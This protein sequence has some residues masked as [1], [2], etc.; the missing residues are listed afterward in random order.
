MQKYASLCII[1][2]MKIGNVDLKDG[3]ILAPMAGV[4]DYT[5]RNICIRHGA[6]LTVTEMLSA[7]AIH[8]GDEKT[9]ELAKFDRTTVPSAI[10]IFGSE[11]D[12]MAESA[13]KLYERFSPDIIDINM[14]CPVRKIVNNG[15][16]S[17]LMKNPERAALI[18]EAVSKALPCPVTVKIRAGW[19]ESTKNAPY[20]AKMLEQAGAAAVAVHGRT[21]SQLYSPGTVDLDIIKTV[22]EAVGIPVIGN[23]DIFSA[24][25]AVN[26][27]EYTSCDGIMLARGA[28]GNPWLFEEIKARLHNLPYTKPTADERIETAKA[29][30]H[31]LI[32][33]KGEY[34]GVREARKQISY[35]IKGMRGAASL[36]FLINQAENEKTITE[37]LCRLN[38]EN[39]AL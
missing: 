23:G 18:C 27:L 19:D 9:P 17:A 12:I 34:T 33:D 11:P 7:K 32:A 29:H 24:D 39:N 38:E 25:D 5:M 20:L 36:R 31:G 37:F 15:E 10:Q 13:K 3:I 30:L 21:R 14:G 1:Y 4:T 22:K 16:G 2:T 28:M 6:D 8:F 35:Y 26:M